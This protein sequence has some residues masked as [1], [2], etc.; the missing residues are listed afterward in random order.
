MAMDVM[1]SLLLIK[2]QVVV[3]LHLNVTW[4]MIVDV[5]SRNIRVL[6]LM[7]QING[8]FIH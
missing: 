4:D 8:I 2:F 5:I 3:Q 6:I 7:V 1:I